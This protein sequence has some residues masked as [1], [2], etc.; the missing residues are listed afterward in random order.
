MLKSFSELP[1]GLQWPVNY[2]AGVTAICYVV[3]EITG[4][5]SQ[6]DRLWAVLPLVYATYFALL[7]LWPTS[8]FL[9]ISF[10]LPAS[11]PA[12]LSADFS[13]RALLMLVLTVRRFH[14]GDRQTLIN[15]TQFVWSVRLNYNTYRRG[16]FN[17][18]VTRSSDPFT[19]VDVRDSHEEDYRWPILRKSLPKWFFHLFNLVFIG[20]MYPNLHLCS[21]H[22][23]LESNHT[24]RGSVRGCASRVRGCQTTSRPSRDIRLRTLCHRARDKRDRVHCG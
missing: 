4:N 11:A 3:S 13:P 23:A 10:Y 2:M 5:V 6:V 14:I 7:P 1:P 8:S 19:R 22:P 20:E 17:L 16:F 21:A 18:Y 9:G 24:G 15:V 12:E